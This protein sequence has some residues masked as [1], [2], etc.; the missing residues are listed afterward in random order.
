MIWIVEHPFN[1]VQFYKFTH[2]HYKLHVRL[3]KCV[4]NIWYAHA[5]VEYMATCYIPV[6]QA[7][8]QNH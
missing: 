3:A 7:S 8:S 1:L 5:Y 6:S 2:M 4:A